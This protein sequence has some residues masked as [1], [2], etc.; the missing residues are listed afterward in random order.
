MSTNALS[1]MRKDQIVHISEY[2]YI[3][4]HFANLD[5]LLPIT[6]M[7]LDATVFRLLM[8]GLLEFEFLPFLDKFSPAL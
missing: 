2:R 6:I 7:T 4:E 3:T 8:D 5:F 1:R